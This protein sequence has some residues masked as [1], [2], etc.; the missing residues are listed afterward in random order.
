MCP[1]DRRSAG[2]TG[3][4]GQLADRPTAISLS[5]RPTEHRRRSASV[6]YSLC[7]TASFPSVPS[8]SIQEHQPPSWLYTVFYRANPYQPLP[9]YPRRLHNLLIAALSP[10]MLIM[11]PPATTCR[12]LLLRIPATS[13]SLYNGTR[14]DT[15]VCFSVEYIIANVIDA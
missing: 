12:T 8:P 7:K 10:S 14:F 15:K 9:L 4:D 6:G 11:K 2:R 13:S 1:V 5:D 3:S